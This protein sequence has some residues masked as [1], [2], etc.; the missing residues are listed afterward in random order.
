MPSETSIETLYGMYGHVLR[1][2]KRAKQ[3]PYEWIGQALE[4]TGS[5]TVRRLRLPME[6]VIWVLI[7]MAL[8]R[9]RPTS[10]VV[11]ELDLSLP[12]DKEVAKSSITQARQPVGVEPL[13]WLCETERI[14]LG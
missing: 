10:E 13:Q 7:G 9:D 6:Q 14:A 4:Q 3:L 2:D 8:V 12:S 11:R 1:A 5:A